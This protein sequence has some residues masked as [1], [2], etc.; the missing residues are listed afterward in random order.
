MQV[1]TGFNRKAWDKRQ[2]FVDNGVINDLEQKYDERHPAKRR[3]FVKSE[4]E[5][6]TETSNST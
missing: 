1:W 6:K 4:I 3:K 2:N 5:L